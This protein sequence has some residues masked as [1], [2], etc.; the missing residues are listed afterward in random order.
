MSVEFGTTG[1]CPAFQGAAVALESEALGYDIQLFGENHNMSADLF[2]EMRAAAEAT[3]QIQ[4]HC[5]PVNFVTRDPGV[6]ASAIAPIQIAS[7]GRAICGIAR[8]D[9]A[10]ALAGR[11]PQRQADLSRDLEILGQYLKRETVTFG[12]RNSRLD[13]IGDLPYTPVPIDMVCSGPKA[14]ALAATKADRIGLS[15]GG[16]RERIRW[17]IEIVERSLAEAGRTRDDVRVGAFIP[18]AITNDRSDAP[19]ALRPRVAGWAHMSSFPGIQLSAQPEIM[20]RVTE[21]LRRDYDYSYHRADVPL[22]NRN[23]QM[24]DEDFADWFG[25]GG[26]PSYVV[27]R[28]IELAEC[29]IEYFVSVLMGPERERFAADVMPAVRSATSE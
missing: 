10:V 11:P 18:I 17:A 1:F 20:R 26:P 21:K 23:T 8:G 12:D 29:G 19:A 24:V 2:G 28:L 6:V 7:G 9:S 15:V 14:I 5:G 16:S 22:E 3:S 25:V 4:L 27:E 13:W